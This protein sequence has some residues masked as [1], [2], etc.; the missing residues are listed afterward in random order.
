MK[1]NISTSK[2]TEYMG[3]WSNEQKTV[4]QAFNAYIDA[5]KNIDIGEANTNKWQVYLDTKGK[6]VCED[7][8]QPF[9]DGDG[10][11][12]CNGS[13]IKTG[14]FSYD[15]M[16]TWCLCDNDMLAIK[17]IDDMFRDCFR[18]TPDIPDSMPTE[19]ED[20]EE[21]REFEGKLSSYCRQKEKY[22]N[23]FKDENGI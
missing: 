9:L 12:E 6:F 2:P 20:L 8:L 4:T 21:W 18:G 15:G 10:M 17:S 1:N 14:D 16:T 22:I 19:A 7:L 13:F 11:I 5:V 23:Y 3:G